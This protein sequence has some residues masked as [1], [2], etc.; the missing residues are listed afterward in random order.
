MHSFS[1]SS[2]GFGLTN[3]CCSG[4]TET[5]AALWGREGD[6]K[7]R[8]EIKKLGWLKQRTLAIIS[9]PARTAKLKCIGSMTTIFSWTWQYIWYC[10]L[11]G[12]LFIIQRNCHFPGC[13]TGAPHSAKCPQSK[14]QKPTA[15]RSFISPIRKFITK[16]VGVDVGNQLCL[17][18]K[19]TPV[20]EDIFSF[21]N[22]NTLLCI[23]PSALHLAK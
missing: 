22:L 14:T 16:T 13:K 1:K 2:Q 11:E 12:K 7:G 18:H 4:F 3:P 5:T 21:E 17:I 9:D 6:V 10:S 19:E 20:F 15:L 23:V 8:R